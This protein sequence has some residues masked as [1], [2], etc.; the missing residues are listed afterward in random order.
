MNK[1]LKFVFII[2]LVSLAAGLV[3]LLSWDIPAPSEK[4]ERVLADDDFPK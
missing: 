1:S 4:V 2:G 3:F